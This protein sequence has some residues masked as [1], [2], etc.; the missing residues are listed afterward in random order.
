M[1]SV[2]GKKKNRRAEPMRRRFDATV[3]MWIRVL[4]F[5]FVDSVGGKWRVLG[6]ALMSLIDLQV[7]VL[8]FRKCE[9]LSA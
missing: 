4:R 1:T 8:P 9:G 5:D 6:G 7:R 3:L 2:S